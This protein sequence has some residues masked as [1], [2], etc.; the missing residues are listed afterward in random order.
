MWIWVQVVH[1]VVHPL[2]PSS[3]LA[4][5]SYFMSNKVF[6]TSKSIS[7]QTTNFPFLVGPGGGRRCLSGTEIP[8]TSFANILFDQN[9][10]KMINVSQ[11]AYFRA[12]THNSNLMAILKWNLY[13]HLYHYF[14]SKQQAQK[15][16]V[17][18]GHIKSQIRPA[19]RKLCLSALEP[20]FGQKAGVKSPFPW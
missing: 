5:A 10:T 16:L 1:P 19:V 20:Q 17:F 12:G 6:A 18:A 8:R 15:I 14:L 2:P 4:T 13:T 11:L 3:T 9:L 7:T